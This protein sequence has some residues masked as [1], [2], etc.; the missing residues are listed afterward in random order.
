MFRSPAVALAVVALAT[1]PAWAQITGFSAATE[2]EQGAPYAVTYDGSATE[3]ESIGFAPRGSDEM[4]FS[5]FGNAEFTIDT[6]P[7]ELYAPDAPG[8]YDVVVSNGGSFT[9][10]LPITVSRAYAS[11]SGPEAATPGEIVEVYW[12]GPNGFD[13]EI[14]VARPDD[15][16]NTKLDSRL[17]SN[18]PTLVKMPEEEGVFELR[19]AMGEGEDATILARTSITVGEAAAYAAALA[20]AGG[21]VPVAVPDKV[22]AGA[23]VEIGFDGLSK[24]WQAMFVMPGES[25]ILDGQGGTFGYLQSN[26][27]KLA[28]PAA[29]GPYELILLDPDR[30][31]RARVPVSVI[32]AV[33]SLEII[34]DV[35]HLPALVVR[36]QGPGS[37]FDRIGFVASGSNELLEPSYV[38]Q[39]EDTVY[40]TRPTVPGKY[41]LR[42]LQSVGDELRLLAT[43]SYT[44]P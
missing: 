6:N 40:V 39:S 13:D 4:V 19:Y 31:V 12:T 29:P 2:V 10:R 34:E 43:L 32:A 38:L 1:T 14:R 5:H 18:S 42:Y 33:A 21:P 7:V 37:N 30:L 41:E 3:M 24:N 23:P 8:E 11:L 16:D 44:V 27:L 17:V 20:D 22:Q 26:P 25:S 36:W 35:G 9:W 15:P 28:A